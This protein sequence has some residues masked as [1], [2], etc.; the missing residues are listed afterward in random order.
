MDFKAVYS[1]KAVCHA[2]DMTRIA[3]LDLKI[4]A[5]MWKASPIIGSSLSSLG[6]GGD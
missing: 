1:L 2:S 5:A 6:C 3:F 4:C